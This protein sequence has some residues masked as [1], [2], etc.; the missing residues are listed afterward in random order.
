MANAENKPDLSMISSFD[1]T[2]LKKTETKE[3][4]FLPTKEEIEAEKADESQK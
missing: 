2:K 1:K 4:Q 3:K